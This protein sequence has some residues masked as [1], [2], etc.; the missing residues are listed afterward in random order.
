MPTC[1][2]TCSDN[3][4]IVDDIVRSGETQ[5]ALVNLAEKSGVKIV[6][7]FFI[8]SIGK[9]WEKKIKAPPNAIVEV[10]LHLPEPNISS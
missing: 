6:G 10:A 3:V 7:I 4:L 5:R 9:S 1:F 2:L 8:I